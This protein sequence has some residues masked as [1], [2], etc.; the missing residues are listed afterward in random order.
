LSIT[1]SAISKSRL[2]L[3]CRDSIR[4]LWSRLVTAMTLWPASCARSARPTVEPFA[5]EFEAITKQ[6]AGWMS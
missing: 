1:T 2:P 4:E 3:G 6:S 5:P